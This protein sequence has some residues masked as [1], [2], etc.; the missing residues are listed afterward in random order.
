MSITEEKFC[1]KYKATKVEGMVDKPPE[2]MPLYYKR[3]KEYFDIVMIHSPLAGKAD[4]GSSRSVDKYEDC[5][6][7]SDGAICN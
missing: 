1:I 6:V 4:L 7:A 2:K 3:I 5:C